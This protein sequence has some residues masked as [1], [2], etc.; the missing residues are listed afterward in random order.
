MYFGLDFDGTIKSGKIYLHLVKHNIQV[1][2]WKS[3][4]ISNIIYF[5][6]LNSYSVGQSK[7]YLDKIIY[8]TTIYYLNNG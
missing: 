3:S 5:V 1:T 7:N 2:P 4:I 8:N 6:N